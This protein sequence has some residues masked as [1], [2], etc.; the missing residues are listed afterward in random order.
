MAVRSGLVTPDAVVLELPLAGVVTRGFARLV[1]LA[2]QLALALMGALAGTWIVGSVVSAELYA[3]AVGFTVLVLAPVVTE[4]V[5]RGRSPGKALFGLRVVG[6]DGAPETPRQALVRGVV[7][8][9]E[10]YLTLGLVAIASAVA[11]GT[12]QR[13]GDLAAGTVVIRS[14]SSSLAATPVAFHP[15]P[16]FESY[17]SRLDVSRL[18]PA[19]FALVREF[20]LRVDEMA[21]AA[22]AALARD[23]ATTILARIGHTLPA[24]VDPQVWLV[25]VASAH[26]MR[27]GGLLRD[28]AAG[29]APL[30]PSRPGA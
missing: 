6:D 13:A 29:L 20:L 4:V 26:Q 7:A 5:W 14:R 1:D 12:G 2:L 8:L 18:T 16:G 25:C 30:A 27:Q 28:A 23:L 21:P 10:L 11:T 22:R 3:I 24:P 19:D 9:V 15:P 17:V